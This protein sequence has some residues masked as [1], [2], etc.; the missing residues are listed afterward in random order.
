MGISSLPL[1]YSLTLVVSVLNLAAK[2]AV[3]AF[4]VRRVQ[5][6]YDGALNL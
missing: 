1:I 3:A 5:V 2:S 6:P 4:Y